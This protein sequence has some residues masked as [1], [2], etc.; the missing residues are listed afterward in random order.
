MCIRRWFDFFSHGRYA[1]G[2]M[3]LMVGLDQFYAFD[4]FFMMRLAGDLV[5]Y[6]LELFILQL[7]MSFGV[8]VECYSSSS[9]TW[10]RGRGGWPWPG[11][12]L[13]GGCVG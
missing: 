11:C 1:P 10:T 12:T 8:D 2:I 3:G 9:S 13:R 7:Q 4:Q 5:M 6:G